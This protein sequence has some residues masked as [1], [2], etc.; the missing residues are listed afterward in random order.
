M[1]K[2]WGVGGKNSLGALLAYIRSQWKSYHSTNFISTNFNRFDLK[3]LKKIRNTRILLHFSDKK[4]LTPQ[5]PLL[6]QSLKF[7]SLVAKV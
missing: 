2:I 1:P 7:I 3:K 6:Y 4:K 5:D